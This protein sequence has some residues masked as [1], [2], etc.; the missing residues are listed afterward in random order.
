MR[1][2][3][4]AILEPTAS[5]SIIARCAEIPGIESEAGTSQEAL[6]SLADAISIA[7]EVSRTEAKRDASPQATECFITV[8]I[9]QSKLLAAST[10]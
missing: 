4:T 6:E 5:G 2:E 3:L 9:S 1:T 7:F 10:A 8:D